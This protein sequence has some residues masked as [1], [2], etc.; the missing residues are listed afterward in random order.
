MFYKNND[1]IVF[2]DLHILHNNIHT[3]EEKARTLFDERHDLS[4]KDKDYWNIF[5]YVFLMEELWT[6]HIY[7]LYDKSQNVK[8]VINLGD[9]IF[10]P[11]ETK[12][13][14]NQTVFNTYNMFLDKC[15]EN[16]IKVINVLWNHDSDNKNLKKLQLVNNKIDISEVKENF[17]KDFLKQF[18]PFYVEEYK[19]YIEIYTH[20]PLQKGQNIWENIFNEINQYLVEKYTN[21]WKKIV[22]YHWHIH[23]RDMKDT[24]IEIF[25]NIKYINTCFDYLILKSEE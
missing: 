7:N 21:K 17:I 14:N 6:K 12:I 23:S 13:Q 8:A 20:Y 5:L 2:S 9:F 24:D 18:I 19:D 15:K 16:W 25:D 22:N 10:N 11:S 1:K 4:Y 3:Y